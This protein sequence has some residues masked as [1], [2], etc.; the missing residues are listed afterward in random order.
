MSAVHQTRRVTLNPRRRPRRRGD[1]REGAARAGGRRSGGIPD[2]ERH[3]RLPGRLAHQGGETP[4]DGGHSP[5]DPFPF[6]AFHDL[7]ERLHRQAPRRRPQVHP[8]VETARAEPLGDV[9]GVADEHDPEARRGRQLPVA[10]ARE[11]VGVVRRRRRGEQL[12]QA[13]HQRRQP[14]ASGVT[15]SRW[16]WISRPLPAHGHP[17]RHR[18]HSVPR[19]GGGRGRPV[20][21]HVARPATPVVSAE[22]RTAPLAPSSGSRTR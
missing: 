11:P 6:G 4:P 5:S 13:P 17:H 10:G 19:G 22:P 18:P 12:P 14:P 2:A 20:M 9:G 7:V 15:P 16:A 8:L 1:V 21:T 3:H